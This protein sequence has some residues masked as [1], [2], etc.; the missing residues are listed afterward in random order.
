[1]IELILTTTF[2]YA[3]SIIRIKTT[4]AEILIK[5]IT[6]LMMKVV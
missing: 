5:H 1:V 6:A 4:N 2:A 3:K